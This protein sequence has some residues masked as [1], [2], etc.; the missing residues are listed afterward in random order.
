M[1]VFG[2]AGRFRPVHAWRPGDRHVDDPGHLRVDHDDWVP[3]LSLPG[4]SG[5]GTGSI[6]ITFTDNYDAPREGTV[7]VR[8]PTP[9][10]GQ[11]IKVEQAGC[12]YAVSQSAFSF[13]SAAGSGTF[14]VLQESQPNTCGGPLQDQCIWTARSDVAWIT[15]T[16]SM[17]RKGDN[18]VAFTVAA[19]SGSTTRTGRI[20][21]RDKVVT[22]TQTP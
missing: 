15:I 1:H 9:T 11:N 20:T 19:N 4:S 2:L 17:P 5:P 3:W 12:V 10:A 18:P 22:I 8:W 7:M 14:D 16:S 21:V 13:T 6:R